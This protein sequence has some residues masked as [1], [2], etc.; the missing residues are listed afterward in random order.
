MSPGPVTGR[1]PAGAGPVA[2]QRATRA[3]PAFTLIE[4]LVVISIIALLIAILLPALSSAREAAKRAACLSNS[5]QIAIGYY[6]YLMETD[7]YLP[8]RAHDLGF[9]EGAAAL[10]DYMGDNLDAFD[11]PSN[12]GLAAL[13]DSDILKARTAIPGHPGAYTEYETNA[14]LW[15]S[16]ELQ[17]VFPDRPRRT[18]MG[19]TNPSIAAAAFDVPWHPAYDASTTLPRPHDNGINIA[20]A[21]GHAAW[22][23]DKALRVGDSWNGAKENEKFYGV[24]HIYA[25]DQVIGP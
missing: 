18:V 8:H 3:R 25:L 24:G 13:P 7:P 17:T 1:G 23:P 12:E 9:G 10:M 14:H 21:D 4:L 6:A 20:F 22:T 2:R 16:T 5:R 15:N 19:I 11:C